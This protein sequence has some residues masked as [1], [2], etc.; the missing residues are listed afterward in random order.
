MA[1][2]IV[3]LVAPPGMTL[4][5]ELYAYGSDS[6]ANSGGADTLVEAT[7]LKGLYLATVTEGLTGW[8]RARVKSGSSTVAVYDVYMTDTTSRHRC[9]DGAQSQE[10]RLE[11]DRSSF[12]SGFS[13]ITISANGVNVTGMSAGV[14]SSIQSG[15]AQASVLAS[16]TAALTAAVAL[17]AKTS[18]LAATGARLLSEFGSVADPLGQEVDTDLTLRVAMRCIVAAFMGEAHAT[19]NDFRFH[20]RDGNLLLIVPKGSVRG[21]REMGQIQS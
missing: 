5:L 20:D 6:L 10:T 16:T 14:V 11:L 19:A 17:T 4:T 15:L 18:E 2:A 3:E 13:T 9:V 1:N 21:D 12:P 8:H 7:N